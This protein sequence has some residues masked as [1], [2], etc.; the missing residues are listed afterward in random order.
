[1]ARSALWA[2][3]GGLLALISVGIPYILTFYVL[4]AALE[5]S[6]YLTSAAVLLDRVFNALGLPGRA[7]VPLLAAAGCNVPALYGT[8]ILATRRERVLASFLITL[9]PCRARSAFIIEALVPLSEMFGYA[10]DLRSMSQGRANFTMEFA[11]Y[12]QLPKA[13]AEK[14]MKGEAI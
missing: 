4:L 5:D 1:M 9:T 2:L 7:A 3:D 13:L 10:T 8:R 6:G 14:I 12:A 11:H